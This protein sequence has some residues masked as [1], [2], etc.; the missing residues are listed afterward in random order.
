VA[1]RGCAAA[2]DAAAGSG[3]V[4]AGGV[5]GVNGSDI[6]RK[7]HLEAPPAIDQTR[8]FA[9]LASTIAPVKFCQ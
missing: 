7:R 8:I 2:L 6:G 4:A 3:G 1:G 5:A 9:F